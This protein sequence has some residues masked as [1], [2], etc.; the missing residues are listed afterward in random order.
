MCAALRGAGA[1][2]VVID[3]G[4]SFEHSVKLQGG[5][6]VEFT[7]KAGFCLNPFSMIDGERAAEDEDY[8]L[9]CFGMV[10]AIVGQMARHSAKLND[11]ERGLIDRA[12]NMVWS[13]RGVDASITGVGEALAGLG[14]DSRERSSRPRSR[15]TWPAGPMAP[16]SKARQA[17]TSMPISPSSRCRTSRAARN[18]AASC[19]PR[20]CS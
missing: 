20:S 16:S 7:M 18:C 13:E 11:T 4:R 5:R 3:D 15:P 19:S 2:V 14:N 8:R 12:V 1:Q 6:F 17:S 10:K 9:D